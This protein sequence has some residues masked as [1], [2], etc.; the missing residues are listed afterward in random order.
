[1]PSASKTK[2]RIIVVAALCALLAGGFVAVRSYVFTELNVSIQRR[3]TSLSFSGF[4]VHYDSLTVDWWRNIIKVDNLVLERDAY[5]TT[6]IYPEYISVKRVRVEDIGL[7]NLIFQNTLNVESIFL[8]GPKVVLRQE[9]L[10]KLDSAG[11]KD[12][13]FALVADHVL[14]RGADFT[15]T[16]SI[17][18][19]IITGLNSDLSIAGLRM[20]FQANHPFE[21]EADIVTFNKA[22]MHLPEQFYTLSI[23][24]ANMNFQHSEFSMDTMKIAPHYDKIAFGRKHG[25]EIDRFEG[26]IPFIKAKDISFSFID[27]ARVKASAIDMQFYL[28]VFRDK[29]LKFVA[30]KKVLPVKQLRALPFSLVIDTLKV[31]KSFVQ[32]EEFAEDTNEPGRIFF[33]NLYAVF[34]GVNNT[35][36]EGSFQLNARSNLLGHGD[37]NLK[38]TFPLEADKPARVVGSIENFSLPEIN[39]MLVPSTRIMVESGE[40]K[41]LS[42][43]FMF[44]ETRSD[45]KIEL[46]YEDL[47]L[48]TFKEDE[49]TDGDQL[50]K[51]GFKTFIMNTFVFRKNMDEDIPEEKRTGTIAYVRDD[52]RSIFNFWVKSLLS[53]IKAAYNLDKVEAKKSEREIKKEKR[54]SR[55]EA[56]RQ[57]R[58]ERKEKARG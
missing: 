26:V 31:S 30:K 12:Q 16:D 53:G 54:T 41:K 56:R 22:E 46:N 13:E 6:C 55:R 10:L 42:F 27:T 19:K 1:M 25:F 7:L 38:A 49:K 32:Y 33:D 57:K 14:I 15:Y 29:R 11:E 50:E 43:Q 39:P 37:L 44:N 51:D 20:N 24:R 23:Q 17:E 9:S 34:S 48:V 36:Q 4:N 52:A 45:G 18:C 5:D 2:R 21:Y 47:K 40:M 58:A 8:D 28:K 3:L 35:T